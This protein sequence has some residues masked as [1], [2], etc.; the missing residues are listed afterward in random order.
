MKILIDLG[1]LKSRV[2]QVVIAAALV[3]DVLSL[4][5]LGVL[6]SV[7][8]TGAFPGLGGLALL[9][10]RVV[11]FFVVV[12][13]LGR[14]VFPAI[15]SRLH[16]LKADE[17]E[18]SFLLVAA[19]GCSVLAEVLGM[20][21]ILGAFAAGLFFGRHTVSKGVYDDVRSK[22][23]AVSTGFLAPIFFA[24]M[25]FHLRLDALWETPGFVLLLVAIATAGK[26]LGA[27]LPALRAGFSR[28]ESMAVGM[29]MN[30]RGAV[31]LVI[32]G[33]ALQAGLFE[34]PDPTPPIVA[35]LFSAVVIMAIVTTLAT[36]VALKRLL[37]R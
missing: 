6:T 36:P 37:G 18:F 28:R 8:E 10:G 14:H 5:L 12:Y 15:G 7:L 26:L 9:T 2:G 25:G 34:R 4:L 27:S 33:V 32:A 30:A 16:K 3:D 24:S 22:I 13:A 29:A 1:Q 21:F 35:N 20:H 17:L 23:S 11:V 19:L 31:E